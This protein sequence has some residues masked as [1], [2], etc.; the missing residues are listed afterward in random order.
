MRMENEETESDRLV[1]LDQRLAQ[2]GRGVGAMRLRI[3]EALEVFAQHGGPMALGFSS[4]AAYATER[5]GRSGHWAADARALARRLAGLPR[6]RRALVEGELGT[7][8]VELLARHVLEQTE[9]ELIDAARGVT[10]R[11]MR[12]RLAQG[13]AEP[14]DARPD[15]RAVA[16][17]MSSAE[18]LAFERARMVIE[19]VGETRSRDEVVEAMLAE[20][21]GEILT[22]CAGRSDVVIPADLGTETTAAR[23]AWRADTAKAERD[24]EVAAEERMAREPVMC[25]P[26]PE[27]A[28]EL[29]EEP[30]ALDKCMREW[31]AELATRDLALAD[32]ARQM[33]GGRGY[34]SLGYASFEQY[35]R[36]RI[37]LSPSAMKARVTLAR[38]VGALP[39]IRA[40]VTAGRLGFET[41]G[42]VARVAAP[43][44]VDAWIARAGDRTV[45]HLRE[46]VEAAAMIARVSG[47]YVAM[48]PPDDDTM[49]TLRDVERSALESASGES[50]EPADAT[51]DQSS[52]QTSGRI[53]LRMSLRDDLARFWR[54]LEGLHR[55]LDPQTSFVWFL[56]AAVERAW[57]GAAG[58]KVAYQD[59]YLRDRFRC[60]NPTCS[61]RDVTPHHIVFRSHG[62][63][64]E[65]SNLTSLCTVCHL[66]LVHGGRLEVTGQ[67][68][69]RL[70][71][72]LGRDVVVVNGRRVAA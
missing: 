30:Y 52:G 36:E 46:E 62:G 1:E 29:P 71:W 59:V 40:A 64:E 28:A 27:P 66:D 14:E 63:G 11:A 25:E 9:A 15:R 42:L 22:R 2:L 58:S 33:S 24:A 61:R 35:A 12:E 16:A 67:A 45:K 54:I 34:V 20:G 6:L 68:P 65:R 21:L 17:T 44:N 38:R 37:G 5:L 43:A 39:E 7:S 31:T 32:L 72:R 50:V 49:A 55:K 3:G 19:A 53:P 23:A 60:A 69:G 47:A 8:M 57:R 70:T 18:A 51:P 4:L 48:A 13:N 26:E 41:A 56:C 10:V